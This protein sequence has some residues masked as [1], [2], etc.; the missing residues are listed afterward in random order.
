MKQTS[1]THNF[2]PRKTRKTVKRSKS[3]RQGCLTLLHNERVTS[4]AHT[5][6]LAGGCISLTV[7][8]KALPAHYTCAVGKEIK[9]RKLF[10]YFVISSK[11]KLMQFMVRDVITQDKL[12]T[13]S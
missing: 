1:E 4:Q 6:A 11:A 12:Q 9:N 3:R 7:P 10:S 8:R 5:L 2:F 13:G